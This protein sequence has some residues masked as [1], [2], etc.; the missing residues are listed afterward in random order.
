MNVDIELQHEH[1]GRSVK[2]FNHKDTF[3]FSFTM[4]II[5]IAHLLYDRSRKQRNKQTNYVDRQLARVS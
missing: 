1:S 3:T 2:L 5:R 4:Y